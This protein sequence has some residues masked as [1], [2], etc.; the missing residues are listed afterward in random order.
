MTVISTAV[1]VTAPLPLPGVM[2]DPPTRNFAVM[3]DVEMAV[4]S[5]AVPMVI[6]DA[7]GREPAA[8]PTA[9]A[10]MGGADTIK[11]VEDV[12]EADVLK[13]TNLV[14]GDGLCADIRSADL[15]FGLSAMIIP[16]VTQLAPKETASTVELGEDGGF[17]IK[18]SAVMRASQ[19]AAKPLP[20]IAKTGT[21][22]LAETLAT[23]RASKTLVMGDMPLM[24]PGQQSAPMLDH[25]I[26]AVEVGRPW[27]TADSPNTAPVERL[28]AALSH[29]G[30][31]ERQWLDTVI[32]D[33][34]TVAVKSADVRFRVEPEGYGRMTIERTADRLEISVLEPRAMVVAEA[35]RPQ[36]LAGAAVLGV[37]VAG[38]T[39]VLDQSGQRSREDARQRQQMEH[40]DADEVSEDHLANIGR[41]A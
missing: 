35:A 12:A 14:S 9:A 13:A 4:D 5:P 39:V 34:A 36:V 17:P 26:P 2:G 33:V 38:A 23:V 25:V 3:F 29:D 32:R 10:T 11:N 28:L 20:S 27:P 7:A 37:P 21:P 8:P 22:E 1:M 18:S 31:A 30:L 15:V 24:A 6:K 41:Y 19:H 16:V 40:R